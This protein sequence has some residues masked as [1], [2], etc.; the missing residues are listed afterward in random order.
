MLDWLVTSYSQW[1]TMK[2]SN[3]FKCLEQVSNHLD[4]NILRKVIM[5]AGAKAA[6]EH[7]VKYLQDTLKHRVHDL[8]KSPSKAS[9]NKLINLLCAINS[10]LSGRKPSEADLSNI[11]YATDSMSLVSKYVIASLQ[12]AKDSISDAISQTKA[13]S[14]EMMSKNF[15]HVK[16]IFHLSR[17]LQEYAHIVGP[18][19]DKGKKETK[20]RKGY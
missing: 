13:D 14:S 8:D 2:E 20:S 3:D 9:L 17:L 6:D 7:S 16:C 1:T 10:I 18:A 4:L 12:N 19:V 11:I 15:D 5:N